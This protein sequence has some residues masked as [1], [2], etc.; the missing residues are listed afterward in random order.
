MCPSTLCLIH[1]LTDMTCLDETISVVLWMPS[2]ASPDRSI[3]ALISDGIS[4]P[5]VNVGEKGISHHFLPT[6]YSHSCLGEDAVVWMGEVLWLSS[7][8]PP[9]PAVEVDIS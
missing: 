9:N 6:C 8:M 7:L 5:C 1:A 2:R 4:C 3:L